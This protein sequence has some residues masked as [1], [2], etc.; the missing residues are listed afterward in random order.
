MVLYY[1]LITFS[2]VMQHFIFAF[3]Y[4]NRHPANYSVDNS[5]ERRIFLLYNLNILIIYNINKDDKIMLYQEFTHELNNYITVYQKGLKKQA[6]KLIEHTVQLLQNSDSKSIDS[7][8]FQFLTEYCEQEIWTD[9]SHRGN[10][11]IPFAL[12][13]FI[14]PWLT[15]RCE[16]KCMPELRWY[17]ELFHN[18][19]IG[20]K[21]AT[22]YLNDAYNSPNCDQ[23]TIDLLFDSYLDIL[24]W[25][26][27]HFPDGCIIEKSTQD[28]AFK[29]CERIMK[30]K[31]VSEHL[32]HELYYYKSLYDCYENYVKDGKIKD[33]EIYCK[34]LDLN[35]HYN[36]AYYYN[37]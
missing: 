17:Y 19:G 21:Y 36:K 23:K 9:L 8:M 7:I 14:R 11:D 25:G 24:A 28:N 29:S 16:N 26:A 20:Y 15:N 33:F 30:E 32:I 12:K 35:F 31:N 3:C 18:D 1:H 22:G 37:K 4:I 2:L 6:N 5:I 34:E 27:H 13:Q 10:G